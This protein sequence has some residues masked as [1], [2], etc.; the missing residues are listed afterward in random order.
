MKMTDYSSV[1]VNAIAKYNGRQCNIIGGFKD[2]LRR[3]F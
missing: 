2:E 3:I 1:F